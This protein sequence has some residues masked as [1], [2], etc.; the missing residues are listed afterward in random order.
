GWKRHG[1][2]CYFIGETASTFTEANSTCNTNAAYLMTVEDRFEQAY[3][4]SLIGLRPEKYFWTGL[5]DLEERGTF[6]WTNNERVLYTHWNADMPGR[7]QGCVVMRTGNRGGLWDVIKCDEKAKFV[8][9]KW[10]EGVTPP[11]IP[12]TTPEPKCPAEWKTSSTLSSCYKVIYENWGYG[13]PNNHQGVELCGELSSDYRL[14]WNDRHCE[15]PADWIC[16]LRKGN[17]YSFFNCR[18]AILLC[19]TTPEMPAKYST[20]SCGAAQSVSFTGACKA[21]VRL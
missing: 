14:S 17:Y 15:H 4:T 20:C 5:T 1:Y 13:E 12:T 8:C 11:P 19:G 2:Y 21:C 9:K 7:K 6:K 3:L 18:M 16:E 10:A